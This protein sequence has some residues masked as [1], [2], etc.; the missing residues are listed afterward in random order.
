MKVISEIKK[1]SQGI[2]RLYVDDEPF[3]ILGGELHNSSASDFVYMEEQVWPNLRGMY[4]NTILLP[5]TWETLEP[6]ENEYDFSLIEGLLGQAER[7]QMRLVLLWFGL[8][9]NGESF[10]VP[11]WVKKDRE[12][13]FRARYRDGTESE[14]ISPLCWEAVKKDQMAY[15]KLME[16]L[17]EN[18]RQHIVIM[19]QVENEIGF[20]KSDRDYSSIADKAFEKEIPELLQNLYQNQGTW[21]TV[22]G[23]DAPE[24]FMAWNYA[25]ALEEI[26]SAGKEIYPLPMYA[27]AWLEQHPDRAGIYPSGG[28]VAKLIPLWQAA[29]PSLDMLSPDIYVPD[30][31][32][33][34][35]AYSQHQNPLFIPETAR[36]PRSASRIFYAVGAYQA[37][38]F[39]P[40]GMEDI[41]AQDKKKMQ[42]DQ[43]AGLNIMAEAFD[44]RNTAP[45][46]KEAYRLLQ[47]MK[48]KIFSSGETEMTGFIQANSNDQGCILEFQAFDLQ[49]DYLRGETGSAGILFSE[50]DGFYLVGCNTR[51]IVLPK[52]GSNTRMEI[53][54]YEEGEF[55]AGKWKRRRILN[56]D[57]RYD[58]AVYNIPQARFVK[59]QTV[60][61]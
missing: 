8:W 51:F 59:L 12:R 52:K 14:T 17:K 43:L 5:V 3:L 4:V 29:A 1:D 28:P 25:R 60:V 7:E 27:N 34:C 37:I 10:Y 31:K 57:E 32:G 9:K 45:Y 36:N 23:A 30:F 46:L 6:N 44:D 41:Q 53:L 13:F 16:Y 50:K 38:G 2:S 42:N 40:F 19:M 22:F 54:R 48:E 24:Y 56:G 21:E 18:D 15:C 11:G 33:E 35:I 61:L 47:G 26:A 58:M 20:L 39:V 49:L 55:V